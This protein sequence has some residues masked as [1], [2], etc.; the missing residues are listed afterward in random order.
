MMNDLA[1]GG[2]QSIQFENYVKENPDKAGIGKLE[3]TVQVLTTGHWPQYKNLN[4]MNLPPIMLRCTQVF[5]DYYDMK[6]NHRRLTWTHSLGSVII[7]GNWK[8]PIDIEGTTL[9]AGKL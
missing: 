6:T 5:K 7:K 1:I 9:Q 2:E 3:F 4:E 8:K